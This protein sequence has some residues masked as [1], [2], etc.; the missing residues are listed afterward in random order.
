MDAKMLDGKTAIIT[1][2]SY[3]MGRSMA[4]LFAEEG[5]NVVITARHREKLD[6]V[7][8]GHKSWRSHAIYPGS[9]ED[10]SAEERRR[11]HQYFLCERNKTVL[12]GNLHIHQGRFKY[13]DKECG[14]ASDR[15]QYSL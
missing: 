1:G 15:Y 7:C 4:E 13:S 12:R 10:F 5:A 8:H 14:D 6:E 3:G 9:A 11:H 2:A